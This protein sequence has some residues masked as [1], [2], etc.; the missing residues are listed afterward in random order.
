MALL[1]KCLFELR[2]RESML[3]FAHDSV[4]F[5]SDE[6]PASYVSLPEAGDSP[7]SD[8]VRTA[9]GRLLSDVSNEPLIRS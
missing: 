3:K 7:A 5:E 8:P 4:P 1:R 2:Q 9:Y 6:S